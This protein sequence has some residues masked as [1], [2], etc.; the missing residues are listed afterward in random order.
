MGRRVGRA[1]RLQ[2]TRDF[3]MSRPELARV[4]HP[5]PTTKDL[6]QVSAGVR[7]NIGSMNISPEIIASNHGRSSVEIQWVTKP[8]IAAA[9][10][11][12]LSSKEAVEMGLADGWCTREGVFVVA[13]G[14]EV[15]V[16]NF[17]SSLDPWR[18]FQ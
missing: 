1:R 10:V 7:F 5:G 15:S 8:E 11:T 16:L 6:S 3:F 12:T 2:E 14:R 18:P 13:D 17:K 9:G 4:L